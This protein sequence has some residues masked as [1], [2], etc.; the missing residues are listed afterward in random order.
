MT[1][2]YLT[3]EAIS[4]FLYKEKGSRFEAY[5]FPAGDEQ[6]G[7]QHVREL[8]EKHPSATHICYAFRFGYDGKQHR[9]SDDGEPAG[10]AGKPILNQLLS[11]GITNCGLAVVR[12]YGG[13]K[14][15]TSGLMGA[16]RQAALGAVL[17]AELREKK[18]CAGFRLFFSYQ[19]ERKVMRLLH[20]FGSEISEKTFST[21]CELRVLIPLGKA[22][23]FV[24]RAG[25]M[26]GLEVEA[27][28]SV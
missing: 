27:E 10:T 22:G 4:T 25:K 6:E 14:L 19:L 20:E 13:T 26:A 21:A 7:K 9:S 24:E 16:Y 28:N 3:V 1:E 17:A 23:G 2:Q 5:L 15:G 18:V 12:Y 8:W 11:A